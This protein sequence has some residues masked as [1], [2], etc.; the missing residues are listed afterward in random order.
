VLGPE[1][2][3]TVLLSA[4]SCRRVRDRSRTDRRFDA[5]ARTMAALA[6]PPDMTALA[7]ALPAAHDRG[8]VERK[9]DERLIGRRPFAAETPI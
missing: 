4:L 9:A 7:R 8:V 6:S 1:V 2:V 3:V 5:D